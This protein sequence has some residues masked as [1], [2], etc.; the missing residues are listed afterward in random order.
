MTTEH[1]ISSPKKRKNQ[2]VTNEATIRKRS[3]RVN[4][5]AGK[6]SSGSKYSAIESMI[7]DFM[8]RN[9][10]SSVDASALSEIVEHCVENEFSGADVKCAFRKAHTSNLQH[11]IAGTI[12]CARYIFFFLNVCFFRKLDHNFFEAEIFLYF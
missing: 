7:L 5:K 8:E 3:T 4:V 10:I 9:K 6:V 1:I 11:R 12:F 2:T